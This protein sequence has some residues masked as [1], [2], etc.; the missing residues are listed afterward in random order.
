M[1]IDYTLVSQDEV[2]AELIN[3]LR[4]TPAFK[5]ANFQGSNLYE[6]V[7]VLSYNS[8]LFGYYLNQIANEPF[9]ESAK[10]YKNI[11]RIANTLLYNPIG[12]S[13]SSVEIV[14]RLS[15]EY[16]LTNNEGFIEIPTYSQFPS[17]LATSSG[18]NFVFTNEEPIIIQVR[19]YGVSF[20]RQ[21]HI[22][23]TGNILSSALDPNR[24]I[25]HRMADH[26]S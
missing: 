12:Q 4:R 10:L 2:R 5:D 25:V 24:M 18:T 14:S 7:N 3:L 26:G 23:Y 9:I 8:A 11:N 22:K 13:S 20:L 16:V 1:S 17:K 19:Q 6:L 21:S 15:K